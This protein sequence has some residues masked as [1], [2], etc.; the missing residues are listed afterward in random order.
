MALR[1]S[2]FADEQ[3]RSKKGQPSWYDLTVPELTDEQRAD[4]DA[5]LADRQ[6]FPRTISVVLARWGYKV[7]PSQVAWHRK[8]YGL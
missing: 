2:E 1:V 7:T 3:A 4:L 8:R 5:A 6:I